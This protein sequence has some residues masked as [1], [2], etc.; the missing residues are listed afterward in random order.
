MF[1]Y[2]HIYVKNIHMWVFWVAF[3]STRQI[4]KL[5]LFCLQDV[6][7]LALSI[8][9]RFFVDKTSLSAALCRRLRL[10]FITG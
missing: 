3:I 5:S 4:V 10:Q 9:I 6:C 1:K 2:K 7:G 8:E